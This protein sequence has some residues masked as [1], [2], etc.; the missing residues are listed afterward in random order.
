MIALIVGIAVVVCSSLIYMYYL[1]VRLSEEFQADKYQQRDIYE[2]VLKIVNIPSV[3]LSE[4]ERLLYIAKGNFQSYRDYEQ[5]EKTTLKCE[6]MATETGKNALALILKGHTLE[7]LCFKRDELENVNLQECDNVIKTCIERFQSDVSNYEKSLKTPSANQQYLLCRLLLFLANGYTGLKLH[8]NALGVLKKCKRYGSLSELCELKSEHLAYFHYAKGRFFRE[9]ISKSQTY[10]EVLQQKAI[11]H[12]EKSIEFYKESGRD[13]HDLRI[14]MAI[15]HQVRIRLAFRKK[16]AKFGMSRGISCSGKDVEYAYDR[17][18]E[19]TLLYERASDCE[20]KQTRIKTETLLRMCKSCLYFR[21]HSLAEANSLA[22]IL[23]EKAKFCAKDTQNIL[24]NTEY[25]DK[26]L[27]EDFV[28]YLDR[29]PVQR[30]DAK[31]MRTKSLSFDS[32]SE[33]VSNQRTMSYNR[34]VSHG[35]QLDTVV[36]PTLEF[37]LSEGTS[38]LNDLSEKIASQSPETDVVN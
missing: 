27:M 37:S 4:L 20:R 21:M 31:R 15:S 16:M 19:A 13:L 30:E 3:E 36:T 24:N 6:R 28:D 29:V 1:H 2:L 18:M 32:V 10:D 5:L 8:D 23:L 38:G 12:F 7:N 22:Y 35:S 9:K 33:S 14:V 17:L 25:S 34:S 11:F 26:R